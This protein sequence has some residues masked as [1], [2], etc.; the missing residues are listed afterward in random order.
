MKFLSSVGYFVD[1][2]SNCGGI[3]LGGACPLP[4]AV[5]PNNSLPLLQMACITNDPNFFAIPEWDL[6]NIHFLY[7][8]KC[9]IHEGDFSYRHT[10]DKIEVIEFHAGP[11]DDG[12]PYDDYPDEFPVVEVGLQ[13]ISESDQKIIVELNSPTCPPDYRYSNDRVDELSNPR[14]QFG[15]VP[16]LIDPELCQKKC[17]VCNEVMKIAATIGNESYSNEM[18]FF[19]N[20]FVQLVYSVCI[21]CKIISVQNFCD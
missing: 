7:S 20:D 8:W 16:Y 1:D 9:G 6:K 12:F 21:G 4:G 13:R 17:V 11:G 2:Q 5:S 15:G 14:H 3:V 18:G 10:V 19:G